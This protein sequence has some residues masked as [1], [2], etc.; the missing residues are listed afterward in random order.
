MATPSRD[1]VRVSRAGWIILSAS[2]VGFV[3]LLWTLQHVGGRQVV[4]GVRRLGWGFAGVVAL[5]GARFAIRAS[6][7]VRCIESPARITF[8]AAWAAF[9]AGDAAGT[10]IP[11]GLLASEPTKA[12]MVAD[13]LPAN[14]AVASIAIE[15]M[16][17][18][19]S[20]GLMIAGGASA[21][22]QVAE[23]ST[24]LRQTVMAATT[25]FLLSSVALAALT[26]TSRR[27]VSWLWSR[28]AT[29]AARAGSS[30]PAVARI[31]TVEGRIFGFASRGWRRWLAVMGLEISYHAISVL[32]VW[33]TLIVILPPA[34][35]PSVVQA[36]V[37]ESVNRLVT[38]LFK[39]VPLRIGID[40]AAAGAVAQ[41]L[42]LPPATGV[43]L[44][45]V[46]KGRTLCWTAVGL[47]VMATR[48]NSLRQSFRPERRA[49]DSSLARPGE[50]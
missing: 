40:E 5:G 14:D 49:E 39:V 21:F 27:P 19:L 37:L 20:V 48:G 8:R 24:P 1:S 9:L 12:F 15:N 34:V 30:G 25:A 47:V 45:L 3:V 13:R 16:L 11:A 22:L 2:I 32:E 17:Y 18:G 29:C 36:F 43:T 6:A 31:A 4:D 7:W 23:V 46:R 26:M 10:V 42:A 44:A 28:L 38:V 35:R 33:L 50:G 41:V